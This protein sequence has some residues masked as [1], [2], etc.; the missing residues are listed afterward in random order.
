MIHLKLEVQ[1]PCQN[2][3][4]IALVIGWLIYVEQL[5]EEDLKG[6]KQN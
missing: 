6:G 4:H 3:N 1:R 5:M 2:R